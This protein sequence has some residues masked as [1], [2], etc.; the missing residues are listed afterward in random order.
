MSVNKPQSDTS[1]SPSLSPRPR[2]V[3]VIVRDGWGCNPNPEHDKFNAVKLADTPIDD[4]LRSEYPSTL[5]HTSSEDVGLPDGTMGNS[6]VGH[7]G[8]QSLAP[9]PLFSFLHLDLPLETGPLR[10]A[11][12][13]ISER[14]IKRFRRFDDPAIIAPLYTLTQEWIGSQVDLAALLD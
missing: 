5:I 7:L 8:D 13:D 1:N 6:E 14:D 9:D 3:V 4:R 10:A 11:G 12:I 2:P